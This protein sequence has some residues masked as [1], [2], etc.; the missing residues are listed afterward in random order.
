MTLH[1]LT[2][3]TNVSRN[4]GKRAHNF[5]I[6]CTSH[7]SW[8]VD[9]DCKYTNVNEDP[10]SVCSCRVSTLLLTCTECSFRTQSFR[11]FAL[12][13]PPSVLHPSL[14]FRHRT[15][16]KAYILWIPSL[17]PV[18]NVGVR[19]KLLAL[20]VLVTKDADACSATIFAKVPLP[21]VLA[22]GTAATA[23]ASSSLA[24]VLTD[25]G[26]AAALA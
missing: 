26:A 4:F 1:L 10:Q 6:Y 9:K 8:C 5:A 22:D 13:P 17:T 20:V 18:F 23:L 24:A 2:R 21:F 25:G 16:A 3:T 19:S 7:R 11:K 14:V 15:L 12:A